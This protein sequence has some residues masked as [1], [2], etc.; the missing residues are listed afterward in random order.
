MLNFL[1]KAIIPVALFNTP[2]PAIACGVDPM[3]GEI[4]TFA[5]NFCPK[6]YADT[7]GQLMPISQNQALFSL[8]GTTYGGDGITNFALP[9]LRGR[10]VVDAGAGV[11]LTPIAVGEQG[12]H[13]STTLTIANLPR[14]AH[15]ATTTITSSLRGTNTTGTVTTPQANILAKSGAVKTYATGTATVTLGTS[16]ISSTGLTKIGATGLGQAFNNRQPY[17]GMTTCIALV[18]IF[19]P[20]N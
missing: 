2:L 11:G 5:F 16:S 14:H 15:T 4:C 7:A 9:D 8:L 20:R 19:P 18:G 13:E 12:G 6:G 10:T 1:K 3:L 17:L